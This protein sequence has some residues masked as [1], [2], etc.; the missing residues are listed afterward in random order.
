MAILQ[1]G[2]AK[3]LAV[4]ADYSCRFDSTRTTKLTRTPG[5]AGNQKTWTMSVWLKWSLQTQR[6]TQIMNFGG[7][8]NEVTLYLHGVSAGDPADY[9]AQWSYWDGTS[10]TEPYKLLTGEH[11]LFR[12]PA[13]WYH[14]VL[15]QDTT[16]AVAANR[17]KMYV[18][19]EQITSFATATY[20]DQDLEPPAMSAVEHIIGTGGSGRYL[21]GYL[22]EFYVVDG[23]ALTPSDFG[24]TDSTTN[25]WI[26]L[27]GDTVKA[28]VTF[29]TN[30]FYL[31]FQD[32]AALGDDSSGNT[33]DWTVTNLVATD[34]MIDIPTNNWCIFNPLAPMWS[35]VDN[36][37]T[38]SEGNLKVVSSS[39]WRGV[40]S[41]F[42]VPKTGKFYCEVYVGGTTDASN[43]N[44]SGLT[45][46]KQD[47]YTDTG[48]YAWF[49]YNGD[50]RYS[51]SDLTSTTAADT[52][53]IMSW[54]VN[55]GEVKI[56]L[57][58]VL[59]YTHGDNLSAVDDDYF[60]YTQCSGSSHF[61]TVN[62]GQDSSFG[63]VLTAQNNDDDGDATADWY[64]APPTGVASL[65]EENL[66]TP[67]IV[68]PGDYF[69]TV[70]YT[71]TGVNPN[72]VTGVGFAP[73]FV[74]VKTITKSG[75]NGGA[76]WLSNTVT[77]IYYTYDLGASSTQS[78]DTNGLVAFNVDG[79]SVGLGGF[80][81]SSD[82]FVSWSWLGGTAPTASNTAG[83]G[84]VPTAGSV[85]ID[86]SNLG[87]AL[88]GSIA[89]KRL[90]ANAASGFSVVE[91]TG[92]GANATVAHGLSEAPELIFVK[93]DVEDGW[94]VG[95]SKAGLSF[96]SIL[97]MSTG[98]TDTHI[99]YWNNSPPNASTLSLGYDGGV[100]KS[101]ESCLAYCFHSVAGYSKV[102]SYTG[103]GDADGPFIHLDFSPA[104]LLVKKTTAS[105]TSWYMWDD[106]RE[107][108]N[109]NSDT[110]IPHSNANQSP[111][112]IG[113]DFVSNGIKVRTGG[114][115]GGSSGQT[116]LYMAFAKSPFKYSNAR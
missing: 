7:A 78:Y 67:E 81:E 58:N 107:P 110:L 18:N 61:A 72:S 76:N 71:G 116:Y 21:D 96:N 74:W 42:V 13:A 19:G 26:P 60:F 80:N 20:P 25:Q 84:A 95:T 69:N 101:G 102:G 3:S 92:T 9:S 35:V 28:A 32:S 6:Y 41:S 87:S 68:L 16:Q 108:Y 36:S 66:S 82:P 77:G 49:A 91:W 33:N 86:G 65:C 56:Y 17:L 73:D 27:D 105:G 111:N 8:G 70:L 93:A 115:A 47:N 114:S 106:K 55:D 5:G 29:G 83:V 64:Y 14:F 98:L 113:M 24:E 50:V 88:A 79:F 10:E 45:P 34:Q 63:G 100:N 1:S 104:W 37:P 62:F 75:T 23:T 57:N 31:K 52:G 15:V 97:Y 39:S 48:V 53:D 109:E 38:M 22:S 112:N 54:Y 46:G 103:I 59:K 11:L 85:K 94:R 51:N 4:A 30:G 89:A 43:M 40:R 44:A 12:D 99:A 2:L 90:S